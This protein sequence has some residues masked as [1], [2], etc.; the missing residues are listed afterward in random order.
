MTLPVNV[1][2]A[3]VTGTFMSA[4]DG[5]PATGAVT[6][7]PVPCRLVDASADVVLI[8]VPVVATLDAAGHFTVDLVGTDDPDLNPVDWTYLVTVRLTTPARGWRFAMAAPAGTTTDLADVVPIETSSGDAITAG[9]PGEPGPP[10]DPGPPGEGVPE[11]G[12]A[13]QVLAKASGDDFDTAWTAASAPGLHAATHAAAGLDPV[14]LTQAQ[15]TGLSAALAA[16]ADDTTTITPTA[17]L[18]G[19]GDL[20]TNRTLAVTDFTSAARGTVPASGGGTANFLRADGT[21]AQPPGGG[22]GTGGHAS[23]TFSNTTT[24]PPS[25]SQLR[26]NNSTQTAATLLY[27]SE[28]DTDGLDVSVGLDKILAGHQIY[29]QDYDDASKWLKFAVTANG[30]DRGTYREFAV[31]YLSGPG[32]IP[33]GKLEL[34]G[35]APGSVGVP[36]GGTT[37]QALTKTAAADYAVGWSN[38]VANVSGATG[39]WAGTQ[40]AYTA[41]GTWSPSVLYIITT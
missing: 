26:L 39:L 20:S 28:T 14:T 35:I 34:Q 12:A 31:S 2:M 30:I 13:G 36:P 11:G 6:F 18:T 25:N 7:E 9:P 38:V 41:L 24:A 33:A 5:T 21:W 3:T 4:D 37:G 16:K 17:P 8:G 40:A 22:A 23:F 32:A 19:G 1:A 15:I 10:G 27:V 29:V